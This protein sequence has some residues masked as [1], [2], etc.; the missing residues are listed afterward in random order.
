M[1]CFGEFIN[2]GLQSENALYMSAFLVG[3]R[4]LN[5]SILYSLSPGTSVTPTMA[6]D[7]KDLVNMYRITGDDWDLWQD[8]AAHFN[9]TRDFS[10][11]NMI[12]APGLLGK[13]WPDLD[14]I[15]LGWL[16]NPGEIYLA[17]FN[18]NSEKTEISAKKSDLAKALPGT[19][20][21]PVVSCERF[22]GNN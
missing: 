15:T 14:L 20:N 12:G 8:V 2:K 6:K 22:F 3:L 1:F 13:S 16:T 7:V 17:F 11:A 5:R 21:L 10:T 19:K 9:V 4:G 18:L